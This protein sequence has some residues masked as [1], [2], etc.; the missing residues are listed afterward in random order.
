MLNKN[1]ICSPEH[2]IATSSLEETLLEID[3]VAHQNSMGF[4]PELSL[5]LTL[6]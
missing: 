3:F 2:N 1:H 6:T 5:S 4:V